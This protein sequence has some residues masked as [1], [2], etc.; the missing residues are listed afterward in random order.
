MD[1]VTKK[2]ED[3]IPY[4]QNPRIISERAIDECAKS[5]ANH[6]MRQA[7][8]IDKNNIIVAGHTRLLACKK[9]D[10]QEVPCIVYEDDQEK[11]DA[12]RLADNKVAELTQWEDNFLTQELKKLQDLDI[13]VAGFDFSE[14]EDKFD[15]FDDLI[16][17]D[18]KLD[19]VGYNA[20]ELSN[21]VPLIFYMEEEERKVVMDCIEVIRRDLHLDT[22]TQALMELVRRYKLDSN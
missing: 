17:K 15:A 5:I 8:V 7:I 10:Y 11:I 22:K 14:S 6:G 1:I 21:Q 19:E 18:V 12:Y 3:L 13:E 4:Y 20:K 9:L 2:V 16:D